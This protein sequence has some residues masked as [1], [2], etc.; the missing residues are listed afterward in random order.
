LTVVLDHFL[1]TLSLGQ[2]C[3]LGAVTLV[4]L[5]RA[6]DA[7]EV[8]ATLL[9]DGAARVSELSGSAQ[10]R[11]IRVESL[12]D[13]TLLL[14]GGDLLRGAKQNRLINT[15]LLV[16][17]GETLEIP[18][19]CVEQGRWAYRDA[20]GFQYTGTTA[21]WEL[22][23][24]A[25]LRSSR[26]MR[27]SG[28]HD[29]HQGAVWSDVR[30]HLRR[31]RTTSATMNLMDAVDE[32]SREAITAWRP[33]TSEVGAVMFIDGRLAGLE[34]F[35]SRALWGA[36]ADRIL[37]GLCAEC[38]TTTEQ[39]RDAGSL[40]ERFLLRVRE[41]GAQPCEGAGIGEELHGESERTHLVALVAPAEGER[42]AM[43]AHLRVA[44]VDTTTAED[45]DP[46]QVDRQQ[47]RR[48]YAARHAA[49][50]APTGPYEAFELRQAG[51]TDRTLNAASE[52]ARRTVGALVHVGGPFL[53]V[54]LPRYE[55]LMIA[56][57]ERGYVPPVPHRTGG[58]LAVWRATE[59]HHLHCIGHGLEELGL[60]RRLHWS[61]HG[62]HYNPDEVP[63]WLA[64]VRNDGQRLALAL[65]N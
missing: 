40:A 65:V 11:R 63:A 25:L 41:T 28:Q 59:M 27:R 17:A 33:G 21:P 14:L 61:A 24:R 2:P 45:P 52:A 37:R 55:Q 18:V 20:E 6:P 15:S 60:P 30:H 19:S 10:V 5:E 58:G 7:C 49:V 12:I 9:V 29:A 22:R 64:V 32:R 62:A 48:A 56:A 34:A 46:R 54:P 3:H 42:P 51:L 16:P 36:A 35:G 8:D 44:R 43:L 57:V 38:N 31:R 26:S 13:Q 23:S 47:R 1:D 53:V 50:G 39:P 4:P